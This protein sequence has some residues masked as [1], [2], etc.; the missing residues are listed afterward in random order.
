MQTAH[1]G[2]YV[3]PYNFEREYNFPHRRPCAQN[4]R[5]RLPTSSWRCETQVLMGNA[6]SGQSDLPTLLGQILK[7]IWLRH[8]RTSTAILTNRATTQKG[9]GTR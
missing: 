6:P 5:R 9:I 7:C 3:E 2:N 8:M 1:Y 4:V